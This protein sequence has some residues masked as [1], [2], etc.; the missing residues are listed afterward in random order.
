MKHIIVGGVAGG[1]TAAA[2]IRRADEQAEIILFEKGKYIS[3]AN[4]GLP[5]YIGGAI[6]EREKLFVQTPASFGGRF[7]ID[8]RVENEVVGI[9]TI[10]KRVEVRRADGSTYA[11]SF[12]KLLLSPGATP[13]RP[14]LE[15]I[16]SEGVFTLRN[17]DDTDRIKSYIVSHKIKSAVIVGAGFIGLEMA[18]NLHHAGAEVSVVEMGNQVMAPVDFS[19][20]SHVHQH[21]LQKGVRLFLGQSVER[22]ERRGNNIEVFFAHGGSIVTDLVILSIGVRPEITLAKVAGLRI[23]DAGG[24]WVDD[25]LQTSAADVYAVG[26]AIEFPHPLTGKSWLNY[27][28]NPA[29]RQGRIVADNMVF[30]NTTKYEGAIGTSIAKVFDITVAS[31]GLAAKRLKQSGIPYIS[32]TTHSASHAGYYPDALPLTLKLTFDPAN[33]KLYGAQCVGYDGVD[34]RIDQIALLIKRGGTVYDL[35]KIEHTYAPP[36]SSAKDPIAIAGYVAGNIISGAMPVVTWR[37]ISEADR[38]DTL[39]LDVRTREEFTFGAIP[40]AVNI[41]LDELRGRIDELPHDKDIYIYCAI[42]LRG[43]LA[44]K[45]LMGHGFNR[46]K[47]LS[48]GYKTYATATAPIVN[49]MAPVDT[50][51]TTGVDTR[52]V[53]GQVKT[54]RIDACGLQCPGPVMKIKQ[55]IDAISEGERIE[56]VATDAGFS[57]D[58]QAW[59][60]TTGNRLVYKSEDK[61]KYTV[62]IE[63]G[64]S[65]TCTVPAAGGGRAKTLIMFS[66]DLDKALATFVLANGAAT[67]GQ[68]VSIFFTF[69]GLNV[70]KKTVKPK[71]KK[72]IFGRMFGMM[73]PSSSL[74]LRLSK[75]SMLGIG[76]RMMRHIM[77]NKGIDSLESLRQQA[78]DSGVEFIACQMSMDVMGVKREELLDDVTVGGVATYMERAEEANVNLFI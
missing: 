66:D 19:V 57:R 56:M 26:D 42:G 46:V 52:R 47:N 5:Y 44:L 23:G 34:K 36:F 73:L 72:D 9:D 20:A 33:G 3:Y 51:C 30:G 70:I 58:A 21:L 63:K 24:I 39:F 48:G 10:A 32:S 43:Y 8:V 74:K 55:A 69:W 49:T 53:D 54:V 41:P 15:G 64:S 25:Y 2:R 50:C 4:C 18:E 45:I 71:V 67:T 12:D 14:P 60:N 6:T 59:C 40:G 78:I 35:Q 68:K 7:N 1:A 38:T 62:V 37:Q 65:D 29:N 13:V 76:D 11:E 77:K 27:L 17:V 22:F 16:D 75:M 61:G 31:T 28:A